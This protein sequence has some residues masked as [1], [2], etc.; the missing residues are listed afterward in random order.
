MKNY[1]ILNIQ[2]FILVCL[3]VFRQMYTEANQIKIYQVI[4]SV[5]DTFLSTTNIKSKTFYSDNRALNTKFYFYMIFRFHLE[6]FFF[7][8]HCIFVNLV[9]IMLLTA[10]L[11]SPPS[12]QS[13]SA[14]SIFFVM[15]CLRDRLVKSFISLS[16]WLPT[17]SSVSLFDKIKYFWSRCFSW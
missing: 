16:T 3:L 17:S 9:N 6:K 8:L 15:P 13:I 1:I 11:Q 10:D 14:I 7:L 5:K 4:T 2:F 12:E